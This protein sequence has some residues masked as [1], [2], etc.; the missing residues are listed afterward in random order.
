MSLHTAKQCDD[1]GSRCYD[2]MHTA[3]RERV[4]VYVSV[5]SFSAVES[6]ITVHALPVEQCAFVSKRLINDVRL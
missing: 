2:S 1:Y 6:M 3:E 4:C 5:Q